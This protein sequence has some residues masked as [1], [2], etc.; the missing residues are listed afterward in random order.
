[1]SSNKN[2]Q[3]ETL[4]SFYRKLELHHHLIALEGSKKTKH[5][6]TISQFSQIVQTAVWQS[7]GSQFCLSLPIWTLTSPHQEG[8]FSFQGSAR[9]HQHVMPLEN[10]H[11]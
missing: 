8:P 6:L 10:F 5:K 9:N 7:P 3:E 4:F 2:V 1:M 11:K